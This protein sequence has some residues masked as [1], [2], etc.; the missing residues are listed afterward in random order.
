MC[1]EH[2]CSFVECRKGQARD[3]HLTLATDPAYN[4]DHLVWAVSG[5]FRSSKLRVKESAPKLD[6]LLNLSPNFDAPFDE[7]RQFRLSQS[8]RCTV[9]C[10]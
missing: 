10:N 8:C 6:L 5:M 3:V 2:A 1:H 4:P 9:R 7:T